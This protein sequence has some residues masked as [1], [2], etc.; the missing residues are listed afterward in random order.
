LREGR[1]AAS[2]SHP[3]AVYIYGSEEIHGTPVIAMELV[4]GGTLK[5][6]LKRN[7]PMPITEAVEAALHV[8]DGL[9][10]AHTA[11]VL[12]RDIKPANCFV[13]GD[14]A[15]K[16]GDFGLSISTLARG[17]SLLTASGSVLGTPAYASPEQLRGENL[18][19]ASDIYSVGATL[20]H[21]L[22]GRPPHETT[23]F[24][25]LITEVL[26]KTPPA[27]D[28]LR[29]EIPAGLSKVILRCLAKDRAARFPTYAALR[30]ALMPFSRAVPKAAPVGLRFVAGVVDEI[31][32][33]SP[34]LLW[35]VLTGRDSFESVVSQATLGAA[36]IAAGFLLIE[37]LYY[38]ITEGLWG[39]SAGKALCGLRVIGP[40]R[41][42]PG[43]VRALGRAAVFNAPW[44]LALAAGLL[45]SGG[46]PI[47]LGSDH[48][49]LAIMEPVWILFALMLWVTLRKRN[50][51]AAV[52]DLI[53]GTRVV[54]KPAV[55]ERPRLLEAGAPSSRPART[56]KDF[57]AEQE[58]GAP[59]AD[60]LGAYEI[61][62]PLGT[63][64]GAELLLARD[65]AL[66]RLVWIRRLPAGSA[67]IPTRRRD[68]SRAAR[69]RWLNGHRDATTAW[70]AYEA[71]DGSALMDLLNRP[72]RWDAVRFWLHDL[73]Q[74]IAA[75]AKRESDVP[76]LA[77]ERIWI[78]A[79]GRALLLDFPCPVPAGRDATVPP[80]LIVP[81]S[82]TDFPRAQ[83]FLHA[84]VETALRGPG[85]NIPPG[86]LPLHVGPFM[87][88]LSE[89]RFEN[90]EFL[91]GNIQS[92][93]DKPATVGR[94]RR[95][96]ALLMGPAF[97][98]MCAIGFGAMLHLAHRR[99]SSD[100]PEKEFPGSTELRS[101]LR[102][103][104]WTENDDNTRRSIRIHIATSHADVVRNTNFWTHPQ[105][106]DALDNDARELARDAVKD[107]EDVS[108]KHRAEAQQL[109]A[110]TNRVMARSEALLGYYVGMAV[111]WVLFTIVFLIDLG[112][113]V[114]LGHDLFLHLLGIA[115]VNRDGLA[116]ARWQLL[117]RVG[118][119]WAFCYLAAPA[120]FLWWTFLAAIAPVTTGTV[121]MG[122]VLP[123]LVA[124]LVAVA[125]W[126][127]G[128]GVQ[129]RLTGT[130][131]VPR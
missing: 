118:P 55:Q 126:K 40:N 21:L 102:L 12:H 54:A 25:K 52:H 13:T 115:I 68:L 83:K 60:K 97:A 44:L 35:F 108:D 90:P 95:A 70:D 14:G 22:T 84:L 91:L 77:L 116:A 75:E 93:L 74:E 99:T 31:I 51:Y 20:Y 62:R 32:G 38:S 8:I 11:G 15:V 50:G 19:V 80:P 94:Q 7:G 87:Q 71:P 4:A 6:T 27:P 85:R 89:G 65:P 96:A 123:T 130:F 47:A 57:P 72:Q 28:K 56:Q 48:A 30:D 41:S 24:V 120:T 16:V 131:L 81:A 122:V 18:D 36:L 5:D 79:A 114:V 82:S 64:E 23:D 78:T 69:L 104:Q 76:T 59:V 3:N 125:I 128:R 39:A 29:A 117:F 86:A 17:E 26:D 103:L 121:I 106:A 67:P 109:I 37:L 113:A 110:S 63:S 33:W 9:E 119:A 92:L 105:V 10:A 88:S 49:A 98:L 112:C 58:L 129:D 73:A 66:R 43:V 61:I 2:V 101:E 124:A 111:F 34:A 42:A 45:L 107:Y 127:P 46:R 100:W 1:L 53:T